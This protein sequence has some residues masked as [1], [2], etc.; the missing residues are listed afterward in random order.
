MADDA[1]KGVGIAAR[2][3]ADDDAHRSLRVTLRLR[4][5][6]LH[7]PAANA[8]GER[9]ATDT[10]SE[11]SHFSTDPGDRPRVTFG[12]PAGFNRR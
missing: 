3:R 10:G 9:A 12:L 2:G 8:Q 7:E 5:T 4:R 11:R 6:V 1:G